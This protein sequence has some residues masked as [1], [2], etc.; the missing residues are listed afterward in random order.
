MGESG[1]ASG[2]EAQRAALAGVRAVLV[3][4]ALVR[5]S[6]ERLPDLL[7]ELRGWPLPITAPPDAT[8]AAPDD[9]PSAGGPG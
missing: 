9:R 3:G 8:C 7:T 6:H 1:I 2:R 5:C 4:E